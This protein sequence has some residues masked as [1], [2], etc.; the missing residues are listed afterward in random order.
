M[1]VRSQNPSS[2]QSFLQGVLLTSILVAAPAALAQYPAQYPSQ[3]QVSKD[4]TALLLED[5]VALPL[6]SG[7]HGGV[8]KATVDY[9]GQLGRVSSMRSEPSNAPLSSSRFFVNDQSGTLC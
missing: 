5:Y 8:A 9:K 2:F 7:T 3:S 1:R 4:G 6:S